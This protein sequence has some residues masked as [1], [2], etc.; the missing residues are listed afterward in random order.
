MSKKDKKKRKQK[1]KKNS[2][3]RKF[4]FDNP[5]AKS[6]FSGELF[7]ID[8]TKKDILSLETDSIKPP[9]KKTEEVLSD[10]ELDS[11]FKELAEPKLPE[12]PKENRARLQIQSPTKIY[13]YWSIKNNP[14]KTLNRAVGKAGNYTLITKLVN[15]TQNTEELFPVETEGNWWFDA[16]AD[17]TYR[18]EIGFYSP[19]RPFIRILFS[20]SVQT[21]RKSPSKHKDLIPRF[22]VSANQFAE[23]L[24]VSGYKRDA[25]EVAFAGDD[26]DSA[27][28][29]TQKTYFELVGKDTKQFSLG[30][31]DELRFAL[32]ALASGYSLED[33]RSEVSKGLFAELEAEKKN[34]R[35]EKVLSALQNNFDTSADELF[36]EEEIGSTVFGASIVHFPRRFKKRNVPKLSNMAKPDSASS[37]VARTI[38]RERAD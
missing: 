23:V 25:F 38:F 10:I 12:L 37:P 21:P 13:F 29:A 11:V 9:L 6:V 34:L 27:E 17:S 14:F 8:D 22:D 7:K 4:S 5:I 31:G 3:S 36:E 32:L 1:K 15:Q 20:N 2:A 33:I 19:N 16:E 28:T 35:A 24:D 18:A 30:K 26:L